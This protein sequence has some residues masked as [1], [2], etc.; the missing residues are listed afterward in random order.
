MMRLPPGAPSAVTCLGENISVGVIE[1][2]MRLPGTTALASKPITPKALGVPGL[3]AKS[4]ISSLSN[5]PVPGGTR[6][7][8][9]S[10]LIVCVAETM[11]PSASMIEKWVVSSSSSGAGWPGSSA[12]GV[13]LSGWIVARRPA[14][15]SGLSRRAIGTR[16]K[17]GS[18]R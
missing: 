3:S 15:Y 12:L 2:S 16:V 9:Y 18:P 5:T 1:L 6:P 13:A 8:P 7:E 11:L 17:S 14:A 10:R 4:S